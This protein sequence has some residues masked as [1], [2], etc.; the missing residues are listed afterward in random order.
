[1]SGENFINYRIDERVAYGFTGGPD[2]STS[3]T[4]M[5]NGIVRRNGNWDWP[6]HRYACDYALLADE[7]FEELRAL[8]VRDSVAFPNYWGAFSDGVPTRD[9]AE[10]SAQAMLTE[11][12]VRAAQVAAVP[13]AREQAA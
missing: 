11:L 8:P 10:R 4:P 12:R 6:L 13:Q 7:V 1:M 9:G 5:R 3:R 2:W